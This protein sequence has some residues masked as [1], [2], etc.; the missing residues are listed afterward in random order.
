MGMFDYLKCEMSLPEE[1][2]PPKIEWFQTKDTEEISGQ[3]YLERWTITPDGRLLQHKVRYEQTPEEELP[4][5]D[6]PFI[7][8]LKT[9]PIGDIEIAFH[10]DLEFH[11][12]DNGEWWSYVARFEDG[13]CS[14][15]RCAEH[16]NKGE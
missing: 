8:C 15:I 1:P 11:H 10:G 14:Q 12:W 5:P 3:L 16:T 13:H 2:P 4:Y 7:G 9:V 6:M